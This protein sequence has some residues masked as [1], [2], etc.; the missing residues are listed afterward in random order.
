MGHLHD[1]PRSLCGDERMNQ[2]RIDDLAAWQSLGEPKTESQIQ[3]AIMKYL[4]VVLPDDATAFAIP[5]EGKRTPMM[6]A[7]LKRQGLKAGVLDVEILWNRQAYFLEVKRED[8]GCS[9]EQ[10]AFMDTLKRCRV[11]YSIVSSV[12]DVERALTAWGIPLK[13]G[14]AA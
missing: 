5:N 1:D 11:P 6:G 2:K 10:F 3:A 13:G 9:D 7:R 14:V 12:D 8:Q 4:A